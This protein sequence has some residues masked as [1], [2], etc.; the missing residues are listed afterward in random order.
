MR[1]AR[2][3]LE[4]GKFGPEPWGGGENLRLTATRENRTDWQS[5]K[6]RVDVSYSLRRKKRRNRTLG[7]ARN[8]GPE[9]QSSFGMREK[10]C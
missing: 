8:G 1:H 4:P 3:P 9:E 2:L 7:G 6:A 10:N 5:R